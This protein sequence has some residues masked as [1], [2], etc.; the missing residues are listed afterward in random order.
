RYVRKDGGVVWVN[1]T[2][3]MIRDSQGTPLYG[4][5]DTQDITERKQ[6][7]TAL[8]EHEER[9]RLALEAAHA[10]TWDAD[11]ITGVVTR[12]ETTHTILGLPPEN[13][14]GQ[15]EF[16]NVIHPDDRERL[17]AV[18]SRAIA[19]HS[20]YSGEF[21]VIRPD[22]TLVWVMN[23]GKPFYNSSGEVTRL[24]GICMDITERKRIEEELQRHVAELK[25]VDRQKD[26]F[27]AVL[28]HEMRNPLAPVLNAV[29]ILRVK[30]PQDREIVWC[31]D[32][33]DR[34]VRH[35][36]RLLDDLLD[37]SRIT[38]DKLELRRHPVE[39][40]PIIHMAVETSR[41]LIEAGE[42]ELVVEVASEPI[43]IDADSARIAQVIANLLNNAAKYSEPR[44]KINLQVKL[45][46]SGSGD[47]LAGGRRCV[48]IRVADTGIG[49][50][51]DKL[52][53]IF[54]PFMQVDPASERTH[55]GL[56]VGLALAKR[57]IEMQGGTIA[58]ASE[59]LGKGSQFT[60]TLPTLR[61]QAPA[62][63]RAVSS[64]APSGRRRVLVV[65]D[66][67][68]SADSLGML[69]EIA[70]NEVTKAY[71]GSEAVEKAE[72]VRPDIILLDL[73]M[74]GMD[75]YET[76]RRIR[77]R[78][79]HRKLLMIAISGWGQKEIR[80]RAAEAGFDAHITKPVDFPELEKLMARLAD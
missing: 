75:G 65:D 24:V 37:I 31:R 55:G 3:K 13:G 72:S 10:G 36:A 26:D 79:K 23:K 47:Q 80:A 12:D 50:S 7:E 67:K 19:E 42:H 32:I 48:L 77:E 51:P 61:R 76:A 34:Q 69:L 71:S 74:P 54:D 21:R 57:L 17:A 58:V 30:G 11:I 5:A 9:L 35:M 68:I 63:A 43:V 60:I 44:G 6:A 73:S 40:A 15:D 27:I 16:F 70:G 41:P 8:R 39:L 62:V 66:L 18:R 56:G 46:E 25:T 78:F 33:I 1:I 20:E 45:D 4:I 29:E 14:Q 22:G 2:A 49:I 28:S 53:H 38:R 64:V 59:G 52:A